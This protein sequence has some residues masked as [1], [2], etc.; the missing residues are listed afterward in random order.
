MELKDHDL[1]ADQLAYARLLRIVTNAGFVALVLLFAA[2]VF[3]LNEA[4][5]PHDRLPD[6]WRLP[7]HEFLE[8]VGI[9]PGWG[10]AWWLHRAD[11]LTLVGIA[12][13]AFASVPCLAVIMPVYWRT[14]RRAL[15]LICAFEILVILLAA[16]GLV[17]G[18]H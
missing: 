16:S 4:H 6:L 18:G 15:F 11:I 12:A 3:G 8:A 10:W 13:L 1:G 14:R 7:A 17:T 5:V 2:Y 9:A